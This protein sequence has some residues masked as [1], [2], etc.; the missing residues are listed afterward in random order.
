MYMHW[1]NV[2]RLVMVVVIVSA[3][4]LWFNQKVTAVAPTLTLDF[5]RSQTITNQDL[6]TIIRMVAQQENIEYE[7]LI[8]LAECESTLRHWDKTGVLKGYVNSS[9]T[10]VFQINKATWQR[11]ADQLGYDIHDPIDNCLLTAW[12]IKNDYRGWNNWVCYKNIK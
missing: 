9:D 6:P 10:G 5:Y 4:S 1:R 7:K 2:I 11:T 3:L 12:I 8:K